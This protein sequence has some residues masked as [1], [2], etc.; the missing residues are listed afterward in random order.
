MTKQIDGQLSLSELLE[1]S[2]FIAAYP[3]F[4]E[5]ADCWC[6]DCRYNALNE[7]IPRDLAGETKPC[8]SCSFCLEAG[9]AEICEIG[10]YKNGCKVR[11]VDEGINS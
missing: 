1:E 3:Q 2:H 7:A 9:S 8:P 4:S 5:C 10:S 6:H 11:A